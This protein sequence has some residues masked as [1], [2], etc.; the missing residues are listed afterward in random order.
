LTLKEEHNID[1]FETKVLILELEKKS[2]MRIETT[3]F[4]KCYYGDQILEEMGGTCSTRYENEKL[5][6][7]EN[8]NRRHFL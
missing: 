3:I 5:L 1:M 2:R 7:S 6:Q 4:M 8:L